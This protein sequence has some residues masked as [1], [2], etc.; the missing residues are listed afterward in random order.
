[1]NAKDLIFW[2]K[3]R[4]FRKAACSQ[5]KL[6]LINI[7]LNSGGGQIRIFKKIKLGKKN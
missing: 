5:Y 7:S 6:S 3:N 2:I 1:M 4:L